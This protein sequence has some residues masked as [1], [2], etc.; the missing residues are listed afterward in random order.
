MQAFRY[1]FNGAPT[2]GQIKDTSK[3][4]DVENELSQAQNK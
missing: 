2:M 1:Y 4:P 3:I